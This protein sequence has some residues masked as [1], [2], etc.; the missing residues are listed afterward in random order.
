MVMKGEKEGNRAR[1]AFRW[2]VR[3]KE[4]F[5]LLL[6][7]GEGEMVKWVSKF[8]GGWT[9]GGNF[10]ILPHRKG[11][12]YSDE[13]TLRG[14][15]RWKKAQNIKRARWK[16]GKRR[17]VWEVGWD[18]INCVKEQRCFQYQC[19][20]GCMW[21]WCLCVCLCLRLWCGWWRCC[22]PLRP[23]V[24]FQEVPAHGDTCRS[25]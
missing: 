24:L 19:V 6:E 17:R 23:C 9:D 25:T 5:L 3:S 20:R 2:S 4:S 18:L 8:Q 21:R 16:V 22:W 1:E 14:G 15:P 12:N 11:G 13:L 10:A 7:R